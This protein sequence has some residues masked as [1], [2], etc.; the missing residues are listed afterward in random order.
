MFNR[1]LSVLLIA[2]IA[3]AASRT[4]NDP[5]VGK[6]KVNPSKSVPTDQMKIDV[7]GPNTYALN[8]IHG[9]TETIVA[10]GTDQ[11]GM[12]GTTFAIIV[13]GPN[14]WRVIRKKEGHMLISATWMLSAD[15]N[16]L[17]DAFTGYRPDGSHETLHYVYER[18]AGESGIPGPWISVSE[19]MNAVIE[20]EILPYNGD[21]LSLHSAAAQLTKNIKF[22]GQD[23]PDVGPNV[24]AGTTSSGRRVN[25]RTLEVTDKFRGKVT[26]IRRIELSRDLETLTITVRP[27]GQSK[28]KD[29]LVFDRE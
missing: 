29:I 20:L 3:E 18:T 15:A 12:K 17:T 24:A 26:D 6:W 16:T 11:P 5:F 7:A 25:A 28:P 10:D 19:G 22:D 27:V 1:T 8:F 9:Q 2:C 4:V 13:E 14:N 21:G 23:Y